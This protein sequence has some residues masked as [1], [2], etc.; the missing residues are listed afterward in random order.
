MR[1]K[2]IFFTVVFIVI[3]SSITIIQA[4][5]LYPYAIALK[6]FLSDAIQG[7]DYCKPYAYLADINQDGTDEMLA[8][9]RVMSKEYFGDTFGI[10]TLFYF[11]K[12][13][14]RQ[15]D[16]I[17]DNAGY[18]GITSKNY[19]VSFGS[20]YGTYWIGSLENGIITFSSG[21]YH[22]IDYNYKTDTFIDRGYM[23]PDET[24]VTEQ[25]YKEFLKKYGLT[26]INGYIE[27]ENELED[28]TEQIMNMEINLKNT[29][30][31]WAINGIN[32]AIECGYVPID[33]QNKYTN[34]INRK[35]FCN[36]AVN[37]LEYATKSKINDIV[38]EKGIKIDLNAF[39]DTDDINILAAYTLG[40][41]SGT[42]YRRFS[43]NEK[44]NREQAATLIMNT[45]RITGINI[46]GSPP[47]GFTDLYD[48]ATWAYVGID[49]VKA[50][51]IMQGTGDNSFNP[52]G[53][54]TREQSIITFDNIKI[55][56][57]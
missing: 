3:I 52:K 7:E 15:E 56:I 38:K 49:F 39:D 20:D 41:T 21:P 51:G 14:L 16:W 25:E 33:L 37:W 10:Y 57:K 28:Q 19:L 6:E 47:S 26:D 17:E 8:Y 4:D 18:E 12:S 2:I 5:E 53:E 29:A 1:G 43:P 48:A 22:R 9:K 50:N 54:Y 44:I 27:I 11:Y 32:N 30:S 35:E 36:L 42:G 31:T 40:I 13:E 23:Y 34:V 46:E 55:G 24:Q 45:V